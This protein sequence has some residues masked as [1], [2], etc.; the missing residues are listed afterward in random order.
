MIIYEI[1]R[2]KIERQYGRQ[3]RCLSHGRIEESP[4]THDDDLTFRAKVSVFIEA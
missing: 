2:R 4:V 3:W 1:R